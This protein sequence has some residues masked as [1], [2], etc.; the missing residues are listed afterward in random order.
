MMV[1]F[2][3][4]AVELQLVVFSLGAWTMP[5]MGARIVSMRA[6][7]MASTLVVANIARSG[8]HP[9]ATTRPTPSAILR[10]RLAV[11]ALMKR[12]VVEGGFST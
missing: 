6:L 2:G 8:A 12:F 11:T 7:T 1:S 10:K 5:S 9:K 3:G 4:A